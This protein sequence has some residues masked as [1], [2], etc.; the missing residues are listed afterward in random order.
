LLN[1]VIILPFFELAW[2]V[3]E[4]MES[5]MTLNLIRLTVLVLVQYVVLFLWFLKT[6]EHH[7]GINWTHFFWLPVGALGV[8]VLYLHA[9]YLVL[10]GGEVNWKGRRYVVNTHKTIQ[11]EGGLEK[12]KLMADISDG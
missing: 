10:F 11:S 5:D 7:K 4:W 6:S 8:S 9:A 12:P 2:V 1:T 3:A